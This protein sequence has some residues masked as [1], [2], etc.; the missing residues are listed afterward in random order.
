MLGFSMKYPEPHPDEEGP[1]LPR[2]KNICRLPGGGKAGIL[3]EK[4]KPGSFRRKRGQGRK[5]KKEPG[6]P[7]RK[8]NK[9]SQVGRSTRE[10][11]SAGVPKKEEELGYSKRK[12]IQGSKGG[13]KVSMEKE[14]PGYQR[15]KSKGLHGEREEPENP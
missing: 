10:G 14:E 7:R 13:A 2:R 11:R 3:W 15:R 8:N 9:G 12:K 4:E 6:P 5:G 1:V